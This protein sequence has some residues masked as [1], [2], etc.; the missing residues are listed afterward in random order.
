MRHNGVSD[1]PDDGGSTRRFRFRDLRRFVVT[2]YRVSIMANDQPRL[3]SQT[4][5]VLGALVSRPEDELSG[6][7]IGRTAKLAT[8]TL[9]PI[10]SRLERAGWVESRWENG[11]PR[12]LGK[13]RRRFYSIT[14]LGAKKATAA[15][16]ELQTAFGRLA[17]S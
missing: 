2:L 5:R 17:W 14:A 8:G 1:N 7:Q 10:L 15:V 9:Y 6:A 3:S 16:D 4:L 11:D 12:I 13:P